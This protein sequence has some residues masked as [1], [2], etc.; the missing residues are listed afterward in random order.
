MVKF[1]HF[2]AD[3]MSMDFYDR[4]KELVKKQGF[5]LAEFVQSLGIN[6][7]TY[8]SAKRLGNYP[9]TD[10]TVAIAKAL[11]TTV[12]YLV[13]G[14]FPKAD[15]ELRELKKKLLEFAQSVQ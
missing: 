14:E 10:E 12:E 1:H 5:S 15:A 3:N 8:R 13:T 2:Y 9:R 6:Y 11:N 4:V 7:E